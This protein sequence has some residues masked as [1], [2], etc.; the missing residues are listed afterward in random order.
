MLALCTVEQVIAFQRGTIDDSLAPLLHQ[1]TLGVTR[2]FASLCGR[3]TWDHAAAVDLHDGGLERLYL[4]NWPIDLAVPPSVT[5]DATRLF[6]PGTV[7]DPAS[8]VVDPDD[9]TVI[10][11]G[12]VPPAGPRTVR[13]GYTG[14]FLTA[15][16]V[17][18]PEDLTLLATLQSSFLFQRRSDLG[19]VAHSLEGSAI[20]QEQRLT[21]L[22]EVRNGLWPYRRQV[23]A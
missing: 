16:G 5:V 12:T 18:A 6:A 10:F 3:A 13:V 1:L 20:S 17:G 11:V 4:R 14:G 8:Y 23:F 21:L 7:L 22:P 9:G 19:L 15:P 2:R